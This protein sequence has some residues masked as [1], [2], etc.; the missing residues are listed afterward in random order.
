MAYVDMSGGNKE[1]LVLQ[2]KAY[3]R[4]GE[5]YKQAWYTYVTSNTGASNFDPNRHD[6]ATLQA[7]L[8][9]TESGAIQ[10]DHSAASSSWGGKGGGKGRSWGSDDWG[11]WGGG[12][13]PWDMMQSM[14]ASFMGSKGGGKGDWGGKGGGGGD[15]PSGGK[16]GDWICPSCS[17]V[18]FSNR[19]SC[20]KCGEP[21][22]N[23]KRLGM[24]PGDWICPNCGDLVF[25][26]KNQCKMCGQPKPED[27]GGG[28]GYAAVTGGGG[29]YGRASPY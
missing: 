5:A 1:N 17:N 9:G 29:G 3:Q 25:A 21:R 15:L 27:L 12:S 6:E 28:G 19:D 8:S 2:V 13:N 16:P 4:Q 24:K 7:F 14:M 18:N 10:P 23:Q 11:G 26:T 20:N 22:G